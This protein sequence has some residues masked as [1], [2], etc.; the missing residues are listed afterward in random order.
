M[1]KCSFIVN[2]TPAQVIAKVKEEE[3]GSLVH[4]ELHN[5][6]GS[7]YYGILIF[8]KYFMRVSSRVALV[9]LVDNLAE[10]TT[11]TSVATGSSQGMVFNFDWGAADDFA[12]SVKE[13]LDDYIT[14]EIYEE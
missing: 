10:E 4:E 8:E 1:S 9:V 7:K 13:M 12:Y 11:V 2:L 14:R 6:D 3:N 5:I